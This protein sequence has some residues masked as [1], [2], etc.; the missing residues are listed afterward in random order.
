LEECGPCVVRD[1]AAKK[2][3][4]FSIAVSSLSTI[5]GGSFSALYLLL[6]IRSSFFPLEYKLIDGL[7][8]SNHHKQN[9]V[10]I[11]LSPH[12]CEVI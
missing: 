7:V 12:T 6:P 4:S 10:S 11:I 3:T 9:N 2:A 8:S 5:F 1:E